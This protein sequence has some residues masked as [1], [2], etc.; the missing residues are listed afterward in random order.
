MLACS[1]SRVKT[2]SHMGSRKP[3]N[4]NLEIDSVAANADTTSL[5]GNFVMLDSTIMFVDQLYCKIFSYD[6]INGDLNCTYS[7]YGQGPNE[8]VGIMYGTPV[9]PG[10]TAMWIFDSSYGIYE[11]I[12]TKGMV[13]YKGRIDLGWDKPAKNDYSS[14]SNYTPLEMSD[15]GMKLTCIDDSTILVPLSLINRNFS[16]TSKTR[17]EK[18]KILGKLNLN[19]L[20]I[21]NLWGSFPDFYS[22]SPLPFFE[23][24]DYA[25]DKAD[26]QI[27]VNHAPDSLIYRYDLNGD[28][29]NTFG[30]EPEGINRN[31]T[32]GFDV[33]I[34][35]F[36]A[37]IEEVGVNTGLYYD[38]ESQLLFRTT[39]KDFSSGVTV[40]QVYRDNDLIIEKLMPSY[41]KLLGKYGNRY[42]GI[43]FIPIETDD[44]SQFLIY[45][46]QLPQRNIINS[47]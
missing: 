4:V 36:K 15:F 16:E 14:V 34:E 21:E 27:F 44:K 41:F 24:F 12:S 26:S 39:M 46:F 42:Y 1:C 45:S 43:R 32:K 13:K 31:Y 29:I 6:R 22:D 35:N 8:M 19:T 38:D 3:Y 18:G 23:F 20:K 30:F 2:A 7:G 10:D 9:N 25:V 47:K 40:M 28:L 37:D 17:Y 5:R 33:S 11:F